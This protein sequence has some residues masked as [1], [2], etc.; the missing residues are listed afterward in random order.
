MPHCRL[1]ARKARILWLADPHRVAVITGCRIRRSAVPA[2]AAFS[3][4]GEDAGSSLTPWRCRTSQ[5]RIA[6][7]PTYNFVPPVIVTCGIL[8]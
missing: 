8:G 7:R 6:A 4:R 5:A 2:T 1:L 3:S